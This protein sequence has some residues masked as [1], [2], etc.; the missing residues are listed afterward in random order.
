M[1]V[2]PVVMDWNDIGSWSAI[3]DVQAEGDGNVTRGTVVSMETNKCLI[4]SDK[5]LIATLGI[6]DLVI[7]DTED[8]LLI[9]HKDQTDKL[10]D[11]HAEI[12]ATTG[13][14]YL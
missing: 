9:V 2:I 13:T 5:R 1:A 8:A 11:L 6:S 3:Y 7:V 10:R 4:Y 12:K 14:K